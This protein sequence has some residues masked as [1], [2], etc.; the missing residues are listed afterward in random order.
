MTHPSHPAVVLPGTPVP[1]ISRERL[2][3]DL[4]VLATFGA[5]TDGGVDRVAGSKADAAARAWL[6]RRIEEAGLLAETDDIGNVFARTRTATGPALLLGSH[7]DTVPAGGRLDGAYGVLAALETLRTLHEAGHPAADGVRVVGFWDEEGARPDSTGG[8]TGSTA[9]VSGTGLRDIAAFFELHIEQGPRMDRAGTD[10][11]VV[12]GIVG[13]ERHEINLFGVPNHAGTTPMGDRADAGRAA[14]RLVAGLT[15]R[16][17]A[18]DPAMVFNVGFIE[19]L[20]GAPNVVPG[21]AR[22]TIEWR[23]GR[24]AALRRASEELAAAVRS[25]ADQEHCTATVERLSHKAI[26]SFDDEVC[27]VLQ[28]ACLRT[29]GVFGGSLLSFAGHD[30]SVLS[31]HVPTAMLFVPSTNGISHSPQESTPDRQ[32]AVG[33]QALLRSVVDWYDHA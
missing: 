9:F 4:D 18:I 14:A 23:S 13:I 11:T 31:A 25:A 16:L 8:L 12:E 1:R 5:R 29:G 32:L 19:F 10:L 33:C 26:T 7:T 24:S 6:A 27:K 30:A 15:P 3:R 22:L 20:P 2:L 17:A 28:D 21:Q